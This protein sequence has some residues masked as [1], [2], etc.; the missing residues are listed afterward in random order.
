MRV[1][2]FPMRVILKK[3]FTPWGCWLEHNIVNVMSHL[4]FKGD[5]VVWDQMRRRAHRD[6]NRGTKPYKLKIKY[7]LPMLI[8]NN[9]I[10]IWTA[11]DKAFG[12]ER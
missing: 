3:R 6:Y 5:V 2:K 4:F 12:G 8:V 1:D 11:Y 7:G 9:W 10:T